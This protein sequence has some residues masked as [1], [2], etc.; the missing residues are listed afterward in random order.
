MVAMKKIALIFMVFLATSNS[1]SLAFDDGDF[2]YWNTES[3]SWKID[4]D[5]GMKLEEEFRFGDFA[6]DYYYQHSDLGITYSGLSE[7]LDLGI[8]YRLVFEEKSSGWKAEN[9]PHFNTTAKL[10]LCG[11]KISDRNRF[12]LRYR[13]GATDGWRYRNKLTFKAP[14]LTKLSIQP[15]IAD[16]IFVDFIKDEFN[17]NRLYGG[18]GFKLIKNLKADLYYLWELN[19][20]GSDWKT[21]HIAG[22][23]LKLSF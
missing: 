4:K 23:K 12:E 18:I 8:S 19:K 16:E 15:Y 20:S 2:Q 9:R 13:E 6:T 3:I 1:L 10:D 21:Y 11:F 22:S 14:K 5:W 7:Y 17:R